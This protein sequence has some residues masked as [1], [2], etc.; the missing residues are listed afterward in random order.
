[1]RIIQTNEWGSKVDPD[2]IADIAATPTIFR[3]HTVTKP[4]QHA[5][6]AAHMRF[7][8]QVAFGRG[9]KAISYNFV[10]FNSGNIFEGRGWRKMGAHTAG[11][12]SVSHAACF[13][14]NFDEIELSDAAVKAYQFLVWEGRRVGAL[15]RGP[16]QKEHDE[17]K[18]TACPGNNVE[19]R[20][21]ELES[22]WNPTPE[23]VLTM[24][25]VVDV[26]IV[27]D[28]SGYL[29]LFDNGDIHSVPDSIGNKHFMG[30]FGS[31]VQAGAATQRPGRKFHSIKARPKAKD[32]NSIGGY[33]L[34]TDV[35]KENYTFPYGQK[36]A[37]GRQLDSWSF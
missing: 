18:A 29:V 12:N 31:L 21:A 22:P 28:G 13:A 37:D 5:S 34:F 10:I 16:D 26:L 35:P 19:K 8:E 15:V 9:F 17:V 23:E 6:E 2:S 11:H 3:H 14:G 36:T 4:E 1:M 30:S 25:G 32:P 33:V 7:I 24:P 20:S 27:P